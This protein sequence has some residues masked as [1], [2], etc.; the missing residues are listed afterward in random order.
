MTYRTI[1]P[2]LYKKRGPAMRSLLLLSTLV[3]F[4]AHADVCDVKNPFANEAG[5][6][7]IQIELAGRTT[8]TLI[9]ENQPDEAIRNE[10]IQLL[11]MR[12]V[13]S[14]QLK[15]RAQAFLK[16]N[17]PLLAELNADVAGLH[18]LLSSQH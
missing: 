3:C 7:S 5:Q 11:I 13:E 15:Q 2:H 4:Q 17:A 6:R 1:T 14:D 8:L 9:S 10:A 18:S 16:R 12:G